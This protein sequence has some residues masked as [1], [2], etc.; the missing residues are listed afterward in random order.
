MGRR[1]A[2]LAFFA[3]GMQTIGAATI[4][5]HMGR[6]TNLELTRWARINYIKEVPRQLSYI[7]PWEAPGVKIQCSKLHPLSLHPEF[8]PSLSFSYL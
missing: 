1:A 7:R 5:D 3:K 4:Q 8:T 2:A 6:G